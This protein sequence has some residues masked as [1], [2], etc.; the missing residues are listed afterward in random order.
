MVSG[1]NG[2]GSGLEES[3][4]AVLVVRGLIE[5]ILGWSVRVIQLWH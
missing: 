1:R 3:N 4:L 5:E 2:D